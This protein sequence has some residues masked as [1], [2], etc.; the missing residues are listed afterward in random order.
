[1][2]ALVTIGGYQVLLAPGRSYINLGFILVL[3]GLLA[4]TSLIRPSLG[5]LTLVALGVLLAWPLPVEWLRSTWPSGS[6]KQDLSWI[7]GLTVLVVAV[8]T[9]IWRR[10]PTRRQDGTTVVA[11]RL[12][13]WLTLLCVIGGPVIGWVAFTTFSPGDIYMRPA[14][15]GLAV[16]LFGL[17]LFSGYS[18]FN[19]LTGRPGRAVILAFAYPAALLIL[20]SAGPHW[21]IPRSP[22]PDVVVEN[23]LADGRLVMASRASPDSPPAYALD[24]R[25][26]TAW[27]AAT[28]APA[29]IEI[30]LGKSSSITE[31]RLLVAQ[32][33]DGETV[34]Q[35]IGISPTGSERPLA[36]FRGFTR[37]GEWLTKSLT[38]ALVDVQS[39]RITTLAGPSWVAWSEIEIFVGIP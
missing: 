3:L 31:I 19:V 18:A 21:V 5:A 8:V 26:D 13:P 27:N 23:A 9:A 33:P 4:G 15:L 35:V 39:V 20:V 10:P 14:V 12:V 29:W 7:G 37:D 28:H 6:Y 2:C 24:G 36:E 17:L 22:E 38:T 30:D 16:G 32:F 11:S 25:E 1:L 34:H